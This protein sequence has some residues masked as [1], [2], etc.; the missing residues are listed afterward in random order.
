MT[1]GALVVLAL[2]AGAVGIEVNAAFDFGTLWGQVLMVQAWGIIPTGGW[3]QPAWP[4]SAEWFVYL[5]FTVPFGVIGFLKRAPWAEAAFAGAAAFG[6]LYMLVPTLSSFG[7]AKLTDLTQNDGAF[8]MIPSFLMGVALWRLGQTTLL[9]SSVAWAGAAL[10]LAW[11]ILTPGLG[12][13]DAVTWVGL[14]GL[15]FCLA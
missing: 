7:G 10:S 9:S 8:P 14:V 13:N 15:I 12:A 6:G 4:I 5:V 3:N 11:V 2:V 1:L